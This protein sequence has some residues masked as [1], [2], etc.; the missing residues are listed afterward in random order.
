VESFCR[1]LRLTREVNGLR[2]YSTRFRRRME[3]HRVLGRNEVQAP[4]GFPLQFQYGCKLLRRRTRILFAADTES[5]ISVR[6]VAALCM[7]VWVRVWIASA[8]ARISSSGI[9]VTDLTGARDVQQGAAH[10]V[11]GYFQGRFPHVGHMATSAHATPERA[12]MPWLQSSNFRMLRLENFSG[13]FP[14]VANRR[15]GGRLQICRFRN[16]FRSAQPLAR[17]SMGMK[18]GRLWTAVYSTW[19]WP[20]TKDRNL[21]TRCISV[22]VIRPGAVS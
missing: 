11:V 7:R 8:R 15:S 5:S 9:G 13:R 17:C 4:L 21:L 14:H 2:E 20:H 16:S 18:Q 12:W 3:T 22:R 10:P 1:Y 19:H 6:A